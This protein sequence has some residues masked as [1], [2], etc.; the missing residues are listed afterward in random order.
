MAEQPTPRDAAGASPLRVGVLLDSPRQPRWVCRILERIAASSCASL[1][2]AVIGGPPPERDA[3]GLLY[4]GY[5]K[6]DRWCADRA[7]DAFEPREVAPLLEGS[8]RLTVGPTG[9]SDQLAQRIRE[10]RLDVALDFSGLR[11]PDRAAKIAR[12]GIWWHDHGDA[13]LRRRG[14]AGVWEVLGGEPVTASMLLA[15]DGDD[16]RILHDSFATTHPISVKASRNNYYWKSTGFALRKL[17]DLSIDGA[18][19]GRSLSDGRATPAPG[20]YR[21]PTNLE[22][23]RFLL[24]TARNG[25]RNRVRRSLA[26]DQWALAWGTGDDDGG[27][28]TD[29][30]K[31]QRLLPPKDRDWAD[32]FPVQHGEEFFVFIEEYPYGTRKGFLSVMRVDARGSWQP[33]QPVLEEP[34]HLSYPFVFRWR[35]EWYMIPESAHGGRV[36]AYRATSFPFGWEPCELLLRDVRAVDPTLLERNGT[37]WMFVNIP[38]EGARFTDELHLFHADGPLG[39]WTPHRRNPVKSDVRSA[40]PAGRIFERGAKLY[41][42]AQDSSVRPGYGITL[43]VIDRLDRGEYAEHEEAK[44]LPGW[45]RSVVSTHTL[46]HAGRLTMSDWRVRRRRYGE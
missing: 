45:D 29:P 14:P 24:R 21:T 27:P 46:N 19:G 17:R 37:W 7:P 20:D 23:T 38:A 2:L 22:M 26:F 9:F 12:Y 28:I 11:L 18:V 34:H 33:P 35:G 36:A 43:N 39:P 8:A 3:G 31:L 15:S 4:R 42:P 32:P 44:I 25:L 40:R 30:R 5:M 41:R 16:E 1:V 6:F 13:R 10:Y